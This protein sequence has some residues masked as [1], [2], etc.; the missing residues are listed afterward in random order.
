[1]PNLS[2]IYSRAALV[3]VAVSALPAYPAG[4]GAQVRAE[5]LAD[6][7]RVTVDGETF[8]EYRYRPH[9]KYPYF[10]P[11]V[12]PRSGS[13]VTTESS[14]P[15]PHHQSLFFGLDRV[16]GGNYWQDGLERG[17]IVPERTRVLQASGEAVEI[18]QVNLWKRP[19]AE[20]PIR[21]T[22]RIR[23]SAPSADL[24]VID[25]DI[26]LTALLDVHVEKTN[27]SLFAARMVPDLA[28]TAGGTLVNALGD[29]GE[30][31]TLGKPAPWADYW[32]TRDG[33][34]EGL[35]IL[36]HPENPWGPS[37]WFTRDYGFFSPT[38][39]N[40]LEDGLRLA[41]G[42]D[43]RLRYRVVV[44]GGTAEEARIAELYRQ[45]AER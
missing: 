41:R 29:R 27:H 12:G 11:V 6:R 45:Y 36:E 9:Q 14:Q 13:S 23:I 4:L 3:V 28:V 40:W 31:E 38:P 10:Y 39:L 16:N 17:Q 24:R 20:S 1:M 21:D 37:P 33:V 8:T 26:T 30:R 15:Y 34:T 18:E 5:Q 2:R 35:A 43:L 19:D 22:R 25:F 7:V 42:E 44:H 32:G